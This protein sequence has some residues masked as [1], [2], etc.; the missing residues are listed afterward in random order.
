MIDYDSELRHQ[1]VALLRALEVRSSDRV[2]DI[3]CGTGQ[4]TREV[5]RIATDGSVCGIDTAELA[6]RNARQCALL[7]GL[8]NV[9]Y[10]RGDAAHLPFA[11][12]SVDVAMSRFGTMFF[13]N[14]IS[15]FTDIYATLRRGRGRL[16]MM[17]WQTAQRN[18]WSV[19]IHR[20][21]V[22]DDTALP[23]PQSG[24]A[25]FSLGDEQTVRSILHAAAF[26]D[27][28]FKEVHEPV[29][30]GANVERA[31]AFVLQFA[32]VM[33]AMKSET[34]GQRER[35]LARLRRT[36]VAHQTRNGVWFDS[37]AWIVTARRG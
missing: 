13:A 14:P 15:A 12:A 7:D 11:H 19:A 10:V 5:A 33:S 27:V 4:T 31:L 34:T 37:R 16:V 25:A 21:L 20:A 8:R 22:G 28:N 29:Y 9:Q 17:V 30:Y 23:E 18:A 2:L 24:P 1:H 6:L 26:V 35:T 3:G 36:M 32:N